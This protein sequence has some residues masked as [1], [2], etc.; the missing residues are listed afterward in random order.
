MPTLSSGTLMDDLEDTVK[1][2]T[3]RGHCPSVLIRMNGPVADGAFFG[4]TIMTV[5]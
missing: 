5:P 2:V 4:F 1:I 3:G